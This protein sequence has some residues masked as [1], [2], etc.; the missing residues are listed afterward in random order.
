MINARPSFLS[1]W[2]RHSFGVAFRKR[3]G[4]FEINGRSY[5][6]DEIV[7]TEWHAVSQLL[8]LA[9]QHNKPLVACMVFESLSLQARGDVNALWTQVM[10]CLATESDPMACVVMT[11][12][13]EKYDCDDELQ[14]VQL[15]ARGSY[16]VGK[17]YADLAQAAK[18]RSKSNLQT[19]KKLAMH[20]LGEARQRCEADKHAEGIDPYRQAAVVAALAAAVAATYEAAAYLQW[21]GTRT[22]ALS[23]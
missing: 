23:E 21:K 14:A 16:Q 3:W 1:D 19:R 15:S 13:V 9:V 6:Y 11:E 8:C 20:H 5:K 18:G 22:T 2:A 4:A 17:A 7:R 12:L 10:A